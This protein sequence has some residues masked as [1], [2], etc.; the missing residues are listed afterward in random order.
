MKL[1]RV[2]LLVTALACAAPAAGAQ[3]TVEITP[4]VGYYRPLGAFDPAPYYT[5]DLPQRPSQLRG[6]AYGGVF[7]LGL[8]PRAGIA[9]SAITT[10]STLPGCICPGGNILPS[11]TNRVT[12]ATLEGQWTASPAHAPV[13]VRVGL[14]PAYIRHSGDGYDRYG[15]PQSWGASLSGQAQVALSAHWRLH[16]GANGVGY[17]MDVPG[18]PQHGTQLD[19]ILSAGLVWHPGS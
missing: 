19:A 1:R 8:R 12:I 3:A 17:R 2:R 9:L 6:V 14:G 10:A 11:S 5:T 4:I 16:V 18:P 7:R 15:T 13:E